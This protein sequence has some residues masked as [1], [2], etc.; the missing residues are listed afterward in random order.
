MNLIRQMIVGLVAVAAAVALWAYHVPAAAPFLARIGVHDLLGVA[1]PAA[2]E[3]GTRGRAP[4]GDVRVVVAAV[5]EGQVNARVSAIG[6]GR[7]A[8]SVT[9]RAETTGL[10]REIPVQP[11]SRV[12]AGAL[13]ARLD[14][15]AQRIALE[16]ARLMVDDATDDLDR[17][18]TLRGSGGVSVVQVRAAE[19]ALRTAELAVDEAEFELERRRVTAPISGWIGLLAV[20]QGDRIGAQDEIAVITDRSS[21]QIDFRVPERFIGALSIGMPL[22]VT[23]LARPDRV[24]RGEVEALDNVVDR[25]SRTLRV[26]G[27]VDNGDDSL[28]AGQAFSVALDFPG[29][30]LPA[31][32]P[33]A[34]QWSGDGS[35]VWAVRDGKAVQ[36]P[37]AIRQRNSDSVVVE[38]ALGAGDLV[39]IEGVQ[40]L[41]PGAGLEILSGAALGAG[42]A[43]ATQAALRDL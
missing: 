30:V 28:R 22:E 14:D 39:V 32:D 36:V 43:P 16:R 23:A 13:V 29:E 17:L 41:R 42:A 5:T 37:V 4:A 7:A 9:V 26:Q 2:P 34:I 18:R 31:V 12:E 8:R 19:L 33:L 15:E 21:I 11:G 27:R 10:I 20:E 25:A 3:T 1:P 24:L 35:F 38:G 6:D 40:G